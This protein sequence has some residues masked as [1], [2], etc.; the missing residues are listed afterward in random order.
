MCIR[1]SIFIYD[2]NSTAGD[3]PIRTLPKSVVFRP[4]VTTTT[5]SS[6]AAAVATVR[7]VAAA[8]VVNRHGILCVFL[9]FICQ[10]PIHHHY[11]HESTYIPVYNSRCTRID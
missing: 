5:N 1:P 2:M 11:I 4:S 8:A 6:A 10:L 7:P 9:Y 3:L